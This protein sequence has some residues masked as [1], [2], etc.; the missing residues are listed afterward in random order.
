MSGLSP[1]QM[2]LVGL[3][4]AVL[5]VALPLLMVLQLLP[6]NFL[7][8]FLGFAASVVGLILGVIGMALY[9]RVKRSDRQW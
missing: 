3:A 1:A 5:G 7:L 6:N 8:N 2:I 9:V 4:L